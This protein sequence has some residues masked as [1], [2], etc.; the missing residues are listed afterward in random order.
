[1]VAC[2]LAS[3]KMDS[4]ETTTHHSVKISTNVLIRVITIAITMLPVQILLV[5]ITAHVTQTM[6]EV[7]L[8]EM[9]QTVQK[10]VL[11]HFRVSTDLKIV[12]RI[13]LN[14]FVLVLLDMK[15]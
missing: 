14:G 9:V 15:R 11:H 2:T 13:I 10:Y 5:H 8:K 4:L 1:M 7:I 6:V 12:T 3:V